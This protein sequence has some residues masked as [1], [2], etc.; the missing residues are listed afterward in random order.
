MGSAAYTVAQIVEFSGGRL[1]N[2]GALAAGFEKTEVRRIA[3]LDESVPG[4]LAFFFSK[5]YQHEM[6]KAAPTVLITAEPFLVP[7]EKSG[8]PLWKK[9][10]VVSCADPYLVMALLSEKFAERNSTVGHLSASG[11]CSVH[12]SAVV[13]SSVKI[14]EGVQIGAH[15]VVESGARIGSG[16]VLY[17]GCFVGPDTEIGAHCVLF[18]RVTLYERT[19]LGDRV[20]IHAGAVIGA[21]GFGYAP[22]TKDGAVT[23]H[24]K[25]YHFGRVIIESDVEIGANTCIDRGTLKDSLIGEGSK[26]D[27]QVMIGHNC[28]MGKGVIVCG[29]VGIAGSVNIGE[30]VYIGGMSAIRNGVTI[31]DRAKLAGGTFASSDIEADDTVGGHPHRA[32]KDFFRIQVHMN[33][34]LEGKIGKGNK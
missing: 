28:R 12:P 22:R 18:P 34:L 16:T 32:L 15:C 1:A 20:R 21:D 9:T 29:S 5:K 25:I 10:A 8:L 13:A 33:R 11:T 7:L 19:K 3:A 6:L 26:I 27:D 17:P 14:G 31:G 23:G 4:D 30:F 24:Q 2:A